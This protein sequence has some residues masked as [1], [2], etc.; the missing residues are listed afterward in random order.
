MQPK[1]SAFYVE[2]IVATSIV[3]SREMNHDLVTKIVWNLCKSAV[4]VIGPDIMLG[5]DDDNVDDKQS[6]SLTM[7]GFRQFWHQN[8]ADYFQVT[9]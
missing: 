3:S 8:K 4:N 2:Y 5:R 7:P 6:K 9:W 1:P